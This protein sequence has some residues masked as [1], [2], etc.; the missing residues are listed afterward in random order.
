MLSTDEQRFL[1]AQLA[2]NAG[3][4]IMSDAD[5]DGLK[6]RLRQANSVVTEQGPRCSIRTRKVMSDASVDYL[7]LTALNLP[8][9]LLVRMPAPAVQHRLAWGGQGAG[10]RTASLQACASCRAA[11]PASRCLPALHPAPGCPTPWL[12]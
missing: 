8:A 10:G 9:A 12:P 4:P 7:K 5:F 2:Y 1:E 6:L 11:A 3:K